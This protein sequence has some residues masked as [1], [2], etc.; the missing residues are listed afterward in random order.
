METILKQKL[1]KELKNLIEQN[2][3]ESFKTLLIEN[4][5]HEQEIDLSFVFQKLYLHACLKFKNSPIIDYLENEVYNYLPEIERIAIRQVFP[6][7]R[8][9]RNKHKN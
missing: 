1:F 8:Y 9:L 3:L 2:N 6:Y 7:G 5:E 4:F